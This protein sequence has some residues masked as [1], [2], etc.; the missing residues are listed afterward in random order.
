MLEEMQK[1]LSQIQKESILTKVLT[2]ILD[3]QS[4][5]D[6]L[7]KEL[8]INRGKIIEIVD[9]INNKFGTQQTST[10]AAEA[11]NSE[12]E[13]DTLQEDIINEYPGSADQITSEGDND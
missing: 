4:Q 11:L 6:N 5:V 1:Y 3:L 7:N 9:F 10:E 8:G 12:I 13:E 2:A